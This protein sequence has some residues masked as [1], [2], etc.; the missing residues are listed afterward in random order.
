MDDD[1]IGTPRTV[2]SRDSGLGTAIPDTQQLSH[3]LLPIMTD[4][5]SSFCEL[6]FHV[7]STKRY[8]YYQ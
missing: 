6:R 7:K 8:Y 2:L 5:S 1:V 4:G 3:N